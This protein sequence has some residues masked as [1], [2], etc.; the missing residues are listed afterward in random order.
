MCE[1]CGDETHD[2]RAAGASR[3]DL[4]IGG[5]GLMAAPLMA[6]ARNRAGADRLGNTG[7]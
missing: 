1:A 7:C 4:L 2:I 5:A 6:M 3:R